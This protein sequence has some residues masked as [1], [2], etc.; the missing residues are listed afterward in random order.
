MHTCHRRL[1]RMSYTE[2]R[3]SEFVRKQVTN[4]AGRQEPLLATVKRRKLAWNGRISR[5]GSLAKIIL[6]GTVDGKQRRCRPCWT[7]VQ[8][9]R[10]SPL[11]GCCAW[12]NTNSDGAAW[13]RRH[14]RCHPNER[15]R[16]SRDRRKM[17]VYVRNICEDKLGGCLSSFSWL[18]QKVKD[19]HEYT[20]PN[21][22]ILRSH[23]VFK[24]T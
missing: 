16:C 7:M 1:M 17:Y 15:L 5:Q 11:P 21:K 2:H 22:T 8:T 23:S 13:L 19:R 20:Q 12:W 3:K 10:N 4:Y 6:H 14:P 18:G 24:T 9:G